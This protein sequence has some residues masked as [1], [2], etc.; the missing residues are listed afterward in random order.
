VSEKKLEIAALVEGGKA[1]GGPPL[2]PAIGPTGVPIKNVI[3]TINEKTK[4]FKGL[5]VPIKVLIDTATKEFEVI[6]ST[7]M[8]SALLLKEAGV[9]SGSGKSKES[10]CGDI[11]FSS[12]IKVTKM[13][14]DSLNALS[15]KAAVKTVLGTVLSVG[16]KVDGKMAKDVLQ[17][18][19]EGKF[20]D[21]L[22]E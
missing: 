21:Q 19:N 9:E 11:P 1:S 17:E 20:D 14:R 5:K 22:K 15:L 16:M 4:E 10:Q 8:T 3:D 6:I 12:V 2:G 7:P 13:K 18:L